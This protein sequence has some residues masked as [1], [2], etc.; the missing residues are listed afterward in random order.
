MAVVHVK[1]LLLGGGSAAA[2]A[3][4]AIRSLDPA[5]EIWLVSTEASRPYHRPPLARGYLRRELRLEDLFVHPGDF[6]GQHR[7][8]LRTNFR[9]LALDT[10]QRA[11]TMSDGGEVFFQN[12]LIATGATAKVPPSAEVAGA[13]LP[14][15]MTLRTAQ[16]ADRIHHA[17]DVASTPGL[18][19]GPARVV[20]IGGGLLAVEIAASRPLRKPAPSAA[21]LAVTLVCPTAHLL[22]SLA[23]ESAARAAARALASLGVIVVPHAPLRALEGDGRVQRVVCAGHAPLPAEFAILAAGFSPSKDLLRNTPIAAEKAILTDPRGQTSVA[24]IFAA[25]ECAAM[26][27]PVFQKH[28]VLDHWDVS[29]SRGLL[30]GAN[31]ASPAAAPFAG[32]TTHRAEL[33]PAKLAVHGEPR[34]AHHRLTRELPAGTGLVEFS[35]D[36]D[37]RLCSIT[38]LGPVPDEPALLALLARRADLTGLEDT[39]RDPLGAL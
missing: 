35:A 6:Y 25:G 34:F 18:R 7:I 2:S 5:G 31:M 14:G 22:D 24:G 23:G 28:R 27:D 26:F 39:L 4:G 37:N 38:T 29:L 8:T 11:V 19:N 12:L 15:A 9:A 30:V 17:A 20:V 13:N 36:Q 10:T 32:I 16:D 21:P 33:G 3:A 1:Y